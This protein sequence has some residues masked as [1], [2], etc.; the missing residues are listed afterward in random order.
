MIIGETYYSVNNC[1]GYLHT[2]QLVE[3]VSHTS[4]GWAMVRPLNG[5]HYPLYLVMSNSHVFNLTDKQMH[6]TCSTRFKDVHISVADVQ[7]VENVS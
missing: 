1:G 3:C 5:K 2:N 6:T 7:L 4:D